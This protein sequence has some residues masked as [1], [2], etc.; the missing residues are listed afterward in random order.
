M[1]T[2]RHKDIEKIPQTK[3]LIDRQIRLLINPIMI[4]LLSRFR[5]II[6]H[7]NFRDSDQS[8][9]KAALG[10]PTHTLQALLRQTDLVTVLS[11]LNRVEFVTQTCK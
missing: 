7:L 5:E 11:N 9:M 6:F 10:C 2:E 4:D 3:R 1:P 8:R